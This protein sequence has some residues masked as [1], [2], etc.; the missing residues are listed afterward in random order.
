MYF[1]ER[2]CD[3]YPFRGEGGENVTRVN[4]YIFPKSSPWKT[5]KECDEIQQGSV[6]VS[7]D[8][9]SALLVYDFSSKFAKLVLKKPDSHNKL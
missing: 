5:P 3:N 7:L 6:C 9:V 8:G 1:T 2:L 4:V